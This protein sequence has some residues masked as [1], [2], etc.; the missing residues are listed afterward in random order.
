MRTWNSRTTAAALFAVLAIAT[1]V[2]TSSLGWFLPHRTIELSG[3]V[4]AALLTAAL[5]LQRWSARHWTIMP[6]SFIVEVTALLLL[7]PEVMAMTAAAGA[8]M[9]ALSNSEGAQPVRR[10]VINIAS[11]AA[12]ALAAGWLHRTLGGTL[13]TFVWPQQGLPIAAAVAGHVEKVRR[14]VI[15]HRHH[16]VF[17]PMAGRAFT[18]RDSGGALTRALQASGVVVAR[19]VHAIRHGVGDEVVAG[20]GR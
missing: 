16:Q 18:A 3:L 6:P 7:G 4:A 11:V 19:V 5:A 2:S 13:G 14:L 9:L 10:S 12:A 20:I 1:A 8:V 15:D 17:F